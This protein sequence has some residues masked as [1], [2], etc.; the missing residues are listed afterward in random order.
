MN[1][2]VK[3]FLNWRRLRYIKRCNNFPTVASTDVAQHSYFVTLLAMAIVD[4][5]N[6][7][8]DLNDKPIVSS[9]L[10]LR[11]ALLHDSDESITSDIPWNVKHLDEDIHSL[12]VS[13]I[14]EKVK[15]LY[16]GCTVMQEY[17]ELS[18]HCKED[19]SGKIVE[20]ADMLELALYCWEEQQLGN[21]CM[22]GLLEKCISLLESYCLYNMICEASPLFSSL[23][24]ILKYPVERYNEM[25]DIN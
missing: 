3:V 17:Y 4:E 11:K 22:K 2:D 10:V 14:N 6:T 25:L 20:L 9:E 5:Y 8:A 21:T 15:A 19:M 13:K 7:Y 24:K 18:T 23:I 12:L 16:E 1:K